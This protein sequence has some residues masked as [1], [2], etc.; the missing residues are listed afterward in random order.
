MQLNLKRPGDYS[1]RAMIDVTR[2]HDSG[3]RKAREIAS[4]QQVPYKSLT[5]ILANL[6][7]AKLVQAKHGPDGGYTLARPATD[8]TLLD[9]IEA[10][11]GPVTLDRC[12]LTDGPCDWD[13]SCPIH[14]TWTRAQTA[15]IAELASTTLADLAGIDAAIQAGTHRPQTE[16][17]PQPTDRHGGRA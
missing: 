3:R 17:H 15:L 9:I 5:Q 2:H 1:I 4:E 11:E 10:A 14:D 16:P 13:T 12:V 8:I 6:V 7:A